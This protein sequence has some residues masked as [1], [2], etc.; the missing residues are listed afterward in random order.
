MKFKRPICIILSFFCITGLSAALDFQE[1]LDLAEQNDRQL[2][3]LLL[4]LDNLKL[5]IERSDLKSPFSL[6]AGTEGTYLGVDTATDPAELSLGS[7][8][9]VSL[10]LPEPAETELTVFFTNPLYLDF[11]TP[12][13]NT[14][15]PTI[16]VHQPINS[17]VG[18]K[19]SEETEKL[20]NERSL[21]GAE[22][23]IQ[24]RKIGLRSGIAG[25][26]RALVQSERS[27]RG[28]ERSI[29]ALKDELEKAKILGSP[30]SGSTE[31]KRM[32]IEL[33]KAERQ[34]HF[35]IQQN[36]RM[37]TNLSALLGME[38][39][40]VPAGIPQVDLSI[41]TGLDAAEVPDVELS[42][43][44][45]S[46]AESAYRDIEAPFIPEFSAGVAYTIGANTLSGSFGVD[47]EYLS[48]GVSV[49]NTFGDESS[50]NA[51]FDISWSLP[52]KRR[53][54]IDKKISQNDL[55]ASEIDL[56]AAETDSRDE[57]ET[58]QLSLLEIE[59]RVLDLE[60]DI[61]IAELELEDVREQ[62][63]L[64]VKTKQEVDDARWNIDSLEYERQLISLDAYTLMLDMEAFLGGSGYGN[65]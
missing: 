13:N 64:G 24:R 19:A 48:L 56:V 1:M 40:G 58:F 41:Y 12:D 15:E 63:L 3:M 23:A 29:Q 45:I 35:F 60:D 5:S 14:I 2:E 10:T 65:G 52:D 28:T 51:S 59:Q 49:S 38:V 54:A 36:N 4:S 53:E 42:K 6:A 57:I 21:R 62:F 34:L 11:D 39:E 46:V 31:F 61:L 43:L 7:E 33:R 26:V 32:E 30:G 22:I 27:V 16:S 18:L 47:F 17:L 20:A 55:R 9:F 8:S 44:D 50:L 25:R 37:K